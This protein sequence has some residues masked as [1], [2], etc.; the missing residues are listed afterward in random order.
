MPA[1]V[2]RLEMTNAPFRWIKA[3]SVRERQRI[4]D[5]LGWPPPPLMKAAR[6]LVGLVQHFQL[7]RS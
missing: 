6:K 3:L 7:S 4:R 1:G 2:K 5:E